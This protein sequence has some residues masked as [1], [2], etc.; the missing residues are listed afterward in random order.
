[1]TPYQ[2][3]DL[4]EAATRGTARTDKCY[5]VAGPM[6]GYDLWNFPAFDAARDLLVDEGHLVISPADLDRHRGIT[7]TTAEFS[8]DDFQIAMRCDLTAIAAFA[9]DVYLLKGWEHSSGVYNEL[10]VAQTTGKG[11][12]YGVEFGAEIAPLV[13]A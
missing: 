10:A 12:R 6:R 7:E 4:I 2:I 1:M 11:I 13:A 3:I 5:Y 9:T 8:P